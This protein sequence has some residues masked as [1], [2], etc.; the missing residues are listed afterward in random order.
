VPEAILVNI[1][2]GEAKIMLQKSTLLKESPLSL[3]DSFGMM[4][5][6]FD[7]LR[8]LAPETLEH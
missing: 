8:Y 3:L 5:P 2:T 6:S 1:G 4:H 7:S